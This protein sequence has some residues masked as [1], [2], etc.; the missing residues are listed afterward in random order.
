M[1]SDRMKK[2]TEWFYHTVFR[3]EPIRPRAS[4][5]VE[6]LPSALRAARSL[7]NGWG[8][9]WSPRETIFL[10][11]AKLLANYEDD[12][13]IPDDV[14]RYF[15]TYQSLTDQELRGYFSWRTKLRRGEVR[16]TSLSF[17]FLYI[18]ELLD[19]VGVEDPMEGYRK[20]LAFRDAYGKLDGKILPYLDEW[21]TDYVVYYALDPNLLAASPQVLFD[22]NI[23]ILDMIA[24]QDDAKVLYAVKQLA[25][26]WLARSKFYRE[27]QADC[28]IVIVRS[29][30][31]ISDHYAKRTQKTMVE[32]FFGRCV[33]YP[34]TLFST[35]VFCDP[36]KRRDHEYALDERRIYRC[37]NGL[38][39]VTQH[40]VSPGH[41]AKLE[42]TLKT[43]DAVMR[44]EY[45]Y[46]NLIKCQTETK[47][48]IKVIREETQALLAQK[49][50]SEAKKVT[51]DYSQL[52]HI[53]REAAQTQDKLTVEEEL[54]EP[55]PIPEPAPA[56]PPVE[57]ALLSPAEHRLLHCLLYGGS[58][59]WVQEEGH[60][61]SVLVDSINEKLYDSFLDT[62]LDD[63]P[64]LI[65]DYIEGLK[66]IVTP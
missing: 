28:D 45:G 38:W 29:L 55:L 42:D 41:S 12:Y 60:L 65:E 3:D 16:K 32:Q 47:W 34:T 9:A 51:I 1:S 48:L 49:K 25:P 52:A 30:R 23:T 66:E 4:A 13:P 31:R 15:P 8:N 27:E 64:E 14:T 50:A 20:L 59:A 21:L 56:P 57:D 39:T 6:K 58:T 5:P 19:Q 33:P 22:R 40:A 63:T 46:K 36:L 17:A 10:K 37:Q 26:K 43:I 2:A 61:L 35:A 24:H 18:Y 62:V 7:E 44:Q 11:Q 53:R 54:E